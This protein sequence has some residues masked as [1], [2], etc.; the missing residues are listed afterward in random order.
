MGRGK[1][2]IT[3]SKGRRKKVG[4]NSGFHVCGRCNGTGRVR[5]PGRPRKK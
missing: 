4:N 3:T 1:Q 5:D 2:T